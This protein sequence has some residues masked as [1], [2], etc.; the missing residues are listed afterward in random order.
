MTKLLFLV[1]KGGVIVSPKGFNQQEKENIRKKLLMN[2]KDSWK[3]YG[4]KGTS[5]D[6]LCNTSGISKGAFYIFYPSKE[7]LFYE[8]LKQLQQSL[9]DVIEETLLTNQSKYGV[10]DALKKVYSEY[11]SSPFLYN[12]QSVDFIS[13][14]NK[15]SN[16]EKDA[17]QFDSLSGA[18]HMIHKPFLTL[19]VEE[20]MALS[21]LASLLNIAT[22]K[23]KLAHDHFKVFEFMLDHLIEE[24]FV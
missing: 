16:E 20:N 23:D 17:L 2:C 9:Y 14:T 12:T 11:D 3:K 5:I 22:A 7:A 18:R 13:F 15:L 10:V 6:T 19:K 4:Y 8:L 21:I 24:I 1:T